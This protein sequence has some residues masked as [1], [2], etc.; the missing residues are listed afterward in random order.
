MILNDALCDIGV[1][2]LS[3]LVQSRDISPVEIVDSLLARI[4]ALDGQLHAFVTV[5]SDHARLRASRA[6]KEIAAGDWRGPLHGIPFAAKDLLAS[7][8]IPSEVGMPLLRGRTTPGSAAAIE[9]MEAA[10]AILLGK[11]RQTE[12]TLN[13]YHPDDPVPV[14]PWAATHWPGASS[15]GSGIALA[16]RMIPVALSSDTGGS[17]RTPCAVGGLTGLMPT[18][19][20]VSIEGAYPVEASLDR[21]GPMAR[22]ARDCAIALT[23]IAGHDR[24]DPYSS[25]EAVPD[26]ALGLEHPPTG[27]T[28]GIPYADFGDVD[29]RIVA[30]IDACRASLESSGVRFM[31]VAYPVS[32][33]A[34]RA[35]VTLCMAGTAHA[36]WQSFAQSAD[37]YGPA[38]ALAVRTGLALTA[39]DM[40]EAAHARQEL[41][42]VMDETFSSVDAM[43]LPVLLSPAPTV[44][45]LMAGGG[46]MS[47]VYVEQAR[48]QGA[49]NLTGQP[50]LTFPAG[51]TSMGM[52]IGIQI[53]GR[54]MEEERL[55]RI[56]HAFQ[57]ST[58]WHRMKPSLLG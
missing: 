5:A 15:S 40:V 32:K 54:R 39:C 18:M 57:Q 19:G 35:W 45:D 58:D 34:L 13:G 3:S 17:I 30:A 53:V 46:N 47:D 23:A 55:L 33:E 22:S 11:V 16:A 27:M 8:D 4:E 51:K 10:G 37:R 26:F 50:S 43:L 36:H 38:L 1:E 49:F 6:E 7:G 28:I 9:R 12:G 42:A 41:C 21:V 2:E 20:R 48:Y 52:P 44:E 29:P 56:V 14:S 24:R 31:D 25:N